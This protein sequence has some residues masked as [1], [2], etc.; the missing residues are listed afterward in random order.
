MIPKY[1]EIIDLIK[2]GSTIEAQEKIMELREAVI[3]LQE[4]NSEQ[5]RRIDQLEEQLA[6]KATLRFDSPFYFADGDSVPYC[7]KCWEADQKTM[8]LPP[9]NEVMS[10]TRYDCPQCKSMFIHPRK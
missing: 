3:E 2:K 4:Q 10:G 7:P 6:F 5:K 9:P 1:S 8:H